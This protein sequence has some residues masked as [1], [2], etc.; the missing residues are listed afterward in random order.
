MR[1]FL[2]VLTILCIVTA[3][4]E[5]QTPI[6]TWRS[7]HAFDRLRQVVLG[8]E[9]VYG[10]S[11]NAV[12]YCDTTDDAVGILSRCEG[13]TEAGISVIAYDSEHTLLAIAYNSANIDLL[14]GG[15]VYNLSD[16][17]RADLDGSK[18]INSIRFRAGRAY[19][20][21]DFGIVVV[22]EAR[23][24]VETTVYL[25]FG[26]QRAAVYD[27][28]F[29]RGKLIAATSI[30]LMQIAADDPYLHIASRWSC[31]SSWATGGEIPWKT[32]VSHDTLYVACQTYFPDSNTLY[33]CHLDGSRQLI[34][35]GNIKSVQGGELG[36][37]VCHWDYVNLFT[38]SGRLVQQMDGRH[39]WAG[40]ANHDAVVDGDGNLWVAHD[41]LGLVK[42]RRDDSAAVTSYLP[43]APQHDDN[44]YRISADR[45]RIIVAPGGKHGT[46]ESAYI[47][48]AICYLEDEHWLHANGS[49]LDSITDII[50]A[51]TSPID[52][53]RIVGVSWGNGVVDIYDGQVTE[54]YNEGN[55]GGVLTP[56]ATTGYRSLRTG[57]VAFDRYGN[58]WVTNSLNRY[59]LVKQATDGSWQA[60]DTYSVVGTSEI[61]HVLYD[62]VRGYIWFYGRANAIYVHDGKNR[63]AYIDPNNGSRKT[64]TQVSS[65]VQDQ[66]GDLW[67]GTNGGIKVIYDGYR[68]F[69]NGG[70]GEKA[71]VNCSNIIIDNGSFVEYLMAYE[72]ITC[73][74]VDGANRKWVGT[75]SGGL[76]L[77]SE[78]GQEE[79]H[80]FTVQNSPLPAN[81]I[82]SVAIHPKT[83]EVFIAT[84]YGV[85]SY[86]SD[87]IYADLTP[88]S[89]IH[90][91]PNPVTPE[92]SGPIAIRGF[93]RNALV[94]ITDAAGHVV[95]STQALG[96][97]A[98]WDGRT[99]SGDRVASGVYYV[100]AS[101]Q[102][103]GNRSVTKILV[104]R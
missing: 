58:L 17:R 68:A 87:A 81:K 94:H 72:V 70:N 19:I 78:N 48:A 93:T 95:Y 92:Y 13:L 98:I 49:A 18:T 11:K 74:A 6:G 59:G 35:S 84:D 97:Q 43:I 3:V 104:I 51:V 4:S 32:V 88:S 73:I 91:Y 40:M 82:L 80:H 31:D 66:N 75:Q 77:I 16:I 30:G 9:R 37:V 29:A 103:K 2:P 71:P 25:G 79:L 63:I 26:G 5:A 8:G 15:T 61:D 20:C 23:H 100:F 69:A 47:P 33:R 53:R 76:Y 21:C 12:L 28:A 46:Y 27:I 10:A 52:Q 22:D 89:D 96:G 41:R 14:E 101:D 62:S 60:F 90:A 56:Y 55:T 50:E 102:E 39:T 85:V 34:D 99:N 24:E 86:R 83:G 36:L 45:N 42:F 1:R 64:T 44:V 54:V 57:G 65:V 38:A 7:H 67:V